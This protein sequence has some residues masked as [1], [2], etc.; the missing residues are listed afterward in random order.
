MELIRFVGC[1]GFGKD[2]CLADLCDVLHCDRLAEPTTEEQQAAMKPHYKHEYC[3]QEEVSALRAK[4]RVRYPLPSLMHWPPNTDCRHSS[5]I[6]EFKVKTH[7]T[8][9]FASHSV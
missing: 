7:G 6:F 4:C 2:V 5:V 3:N 9:C 8:F 1:K